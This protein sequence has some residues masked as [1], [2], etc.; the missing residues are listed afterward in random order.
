V[1]TEGDPQRR[2][3]ESV[4]TRIERQERDYAVRARRPL[5]LMFAGVML[6]NLTN[7][8]NLAGVDLP[9]VV[10]VISGVSGVTMAVVGFVQSR[11]TRKWMGL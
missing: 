10:I 1:A 4:W 7:L 5:A 9:F 8:V 3:G 6:L 2:A 11:R